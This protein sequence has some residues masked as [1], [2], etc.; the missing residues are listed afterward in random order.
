MQQSFS[1]PKTGK[2]FMLASLTKVPKL[3]R[4]IWSEDQIWKRDK[5]NHTLWWKNSCLCCHSSF[6]WFPTKLCQFQRK[7]I[8][9]F[10]IVML[11]GMK[12]KMKSCHL[13]SQKTAPTSDVCNDPPQKSPKAPSWTCK[14]SL[15]LS[16]SVRLQIKKSNRAIQCRN[17]DMT[18]LVGIGLKID[19]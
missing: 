19:P 16:K 15:W 2:K 11:F 12:K 5:K 10:S 14:N 9:R 13:F 3:S 8:L 4:K 6:F 1:H 7:E 18:F 17:S